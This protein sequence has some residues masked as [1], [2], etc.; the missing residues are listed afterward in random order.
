MSENVS[1]SSKTLPQPRKVK[2]GETLS[3]KERQNS[4]ESV[5]KKTVKLETTNTALRS[6]LS[7]AATPDILKQT[8]EIA[9]NSVAIQVD[10]LQH[11]LEEQTQVSTE[12]E[13]KADALFAA[14]GQR[15]REFEACLVALQVYAEKVRI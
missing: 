5:K 4:E 3:F 7:S 14:M 13:R 15:N 10:T 6:C 2:T 11:E 1:T 12:K 9:R 8:P